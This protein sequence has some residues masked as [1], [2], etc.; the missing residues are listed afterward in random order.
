MANG[1]FGHK[2]ILLSRVSTSKQQLQEG[3]SP[4]QNDLRAWA[5]QLGYTDLR[6]IDS[7]ESGFLDLDARS[8]WNAIF[9]FIEENPDYRTIIATEI[10]RLARNESVL[11]EVKEYLYNNKIQLL[12]KDL[13][14]RLLTIDGEKSS[15]ADLLFNIYA[16]MAKFEM[17]NKNDRKQRALTEY[18]KKGYSIGGAKLF[19]Y[20][21]E[22]GDL[23][24]K[25]KY[26]TNEAEANEIRTIYAWYAR[27]IDADTPNPS[28]LRITQECIARGMSK[29][30]HS[31]RNVG[32]CL[33]EE[34]YTGYKITKNKTRN[35]EYWNYLKK[36]A[37]KYVD[38]VQYECVYPEIIPLPLFNEVKEKRDKRNPHNKEDVGMYVDKSRKHITLLSKVLKCPCCGKYLVGEYRKS[39]S[40]LRNTYRC[41]S[42]RGVIEKCNFKS[43]LSML[44]MDSAIWS[45][46]RQYAQLIIKAKENALNNANVAEMQKEISRLEDELKKYDVQLESEDD[47]FRAKI[48]R[49]P[50]EEGRRKAKAEYEERIKTINLRK[51]S[52][53]KGIVKRKNRLC[54]ISA[55]KQ[56]ICHINEIDLSRVEGSKNE[57]YYYIHLLL[58]SVQPIHVA[59]S[60][61]VLQIDSY[62]NDSDILSVEGNKEIH[63]R[64]FL[65]LDKRNTNRIQLYCFGGMYEWD[66]EQKR[67]AAI[68]SK[69]TCTA[70]AI[71]DYLRMGFANNEIPPMAKANVDFHIAQLNYNKL[72]CYNEDK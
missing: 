9:K 37:P 72:Q 3:F 46:L 40:H 5:I 13:D 7:I 44:L 24:N 50:T 65:L 15:M 6:P 52:I 34:A 33:K 25:K 59:K 20:I 18:R 55:Q 48:R 47:I 17:L 70:E 45:Y 53:D 51:E 31:K 27:G 12:I 14:F 2:A 57:M 63:M 36:D 49:N 4:Q 8:G 1:I 41:A 58:G 60:F 22:I 26:V 11:M 10:N 68:E 71:I 42:G 29:Y 67:F 19:G 16:S 28:V 69:Y 23:G 39:E 54:A 35:K 38:A 64:E 32:K 62:F 21:R 43:S 30:L 66:S 61:Y 56:T